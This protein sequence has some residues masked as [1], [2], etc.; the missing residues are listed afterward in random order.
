MGRRPVLAVP[1]PS[2]RCQMALL[3]TCPAIQPLG[4]TA[5]G[6]LVREI[7]ALGGLMGK[8]IDATGIQF[9]LLDQESRAGR[10][11]AACTGGQAAVQANRCA[12]LSKLFPRSTGSSTPAT[13]I[14]P[15]GLGRLHGLELAD[16]Q[17]RHLPR[18]WLTTGTFLM[19]W[20]ISV[21]SRSRLVVRA[22]HVP[23]PRRVIKGVWFQMGPP[24]DRHAAP[25]GPSLDRLQSLFQVER[26]D[27]PP[28]PFSFETDSIDR[29][30][31]DCHLL[32]T[33][34]R[35]HDLVRSNINHSPL[36]N[37]RILRYRAALLSLARRQGDAL[38]Q[39]RTPP[40]LPRAR[41]SG[42]RR[43][44]RQR[45]FHES[46]AGNSERTG[47]SAAGTRGRGDDAARLR[48]GI[49]LHPTDGASLHTGGAPGS[50]ALPRG[51]D[52]RN[53]R[54]RGGCGAGPGCG[55]QRCALCAKRTGFYA[56][57]R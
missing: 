1:L 39:P 47:S 28:V 54:L 33:N 22:S 45:L 3:G 51:T 27:D 40:D 23:G 14:L 9:K 38:P 21:R 19:A 41:G 16:Q 10:L 34:D 57:P 44:L 46:A 37:G 17:R 2:A 50:P 30:Q 7:D 5:K 42:R 25:A 31:I 11:V 20:F 52:Q 55:D 49:R 43:D 13:R 35:V 8:A 56:R 32:Y 24:Q 15:G 48:R 36:F 53:V 6:H 26:G 4:G 18:P 29:P 12:R